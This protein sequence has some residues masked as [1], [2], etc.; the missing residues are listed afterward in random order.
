MVY[1]WM[2]S[3]QLSRM[4]SK[5]RLVIPSTTQSNLLTRNMFRNFPSILLSTRTWC[6]TMAYYQNLI[7]LMFVIMEF[8]ANILV[9]YFDLWFLNTILFNPILI[10]TPI[11]EFSLKGKPS[12][13]PFS[14]Y[15]ML[16]DITSLSH[17]QI[18]IHDYV[19]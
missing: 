7:I 9:G 10:L 1:L 16:P 14:P 2:P 17:V 4:H 8:T 6:S 3:I 13:C 11:G 18:M 19:G 15:L 5:M 12:K